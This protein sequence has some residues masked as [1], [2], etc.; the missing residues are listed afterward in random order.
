MKYI[1]WALFGVICIYQ[2][3]DGQQT[4]L[5]LQL[6]LKEANPIIRLCIREFGIIW[7]L[8]L[9]KLFAMTMLGIGLYYYQKKV[10]D[11]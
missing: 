2:W 5:L 7:G 3:V 10:K 4:Y 1:I 11:A 8:V 9:P 6:G